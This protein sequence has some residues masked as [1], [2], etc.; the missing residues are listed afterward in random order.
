MDIGS[1]ISSGGRTHSLLITYSQISFNAACSS[2][3]Q[4]FHKAKSPWGEVTR[5]SEGHTIY[6]SFKDTS[7]M[8]KRIFT[9][10]ARFES[11]S[12]I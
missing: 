12:E 7:F 9:C 10:H 8:A 2:A 3:V 4:V 11:S 1:S 6:S 5:S